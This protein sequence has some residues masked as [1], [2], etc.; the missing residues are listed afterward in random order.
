[1]TFLENIPNDEILDFIV[2]K[3]HAVNDNQTI[4]G[5]VTIIKNEGKPNEEVIVKN[6]HNLLTNA[7]KD[8]FHDQCYTNTSA[9]GVGCRFVGLSQDSTNPAATDTNLSAG[10]GEI[11]TGGLNRQI[12]DTASTSGSVTTLVKTYNSTATFTTVQKS[13]LFNASSS[14][15]MAHA[16]KFTSVALVNGD[17]LAVTWLLTMG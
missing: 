8:Y 7:G 4:H 6:K 14:G 10:S 3:S 11:T 2:G 5:Y 13:G 12:S 15:T 9:G 1:M 16:A 17:T